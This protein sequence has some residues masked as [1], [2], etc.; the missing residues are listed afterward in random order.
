[1]R[2]LELVST[3]PA[4]K[5]KAHLNLKPPPS[6]P[7][8][9]PHRHRLL[10]VH[11]LVRPPGL[12]QNPPHNPILPVRVLHHIIIHHHRPLLPLPLL[13]H[14]P[15]PRRLDFNLRILIPKVP[16]HPQRIPE[17]YV[18]PV[19]HAPIGRDVDVPLDAVRVEVRVGR[20]EFEAPAAVDAAGADV[21]VAALLLAVGEGAAEL[22]EDDVFGETGP[23]DEDEDVDDGFGEEGGD[24]GAADVFDGE[25]V[26]GQGGEVV[27]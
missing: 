16:V 19:H 13:S 26:R 21:V 9:I 3:Y 27:G 14:P 5:Q 10:L 25:E 7:R 15:H 4:S 2:Y 6:L 24:G 23:G 22:L 12:F 18:V 17:R 11:L 8:P 1:M 20:A